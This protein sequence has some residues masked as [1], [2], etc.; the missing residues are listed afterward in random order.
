MFVC[1]RKILISCG[2][3]GVSLCEAELLFELF[4]RK[5]APL[6]SVSIDNT[7]LQESFISGHILKESKIKEKIFIKVR[8]LDT[9]FLTKP[10]SFS[11]HKASQIGPATCMPASLAPLA[12]FW[13]AN[14]ITSSHFPSAANCFASAISSFIYWI[15]SVSFFFALLAGASIDA[16]G[17]LF[18]KRRR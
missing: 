12:F 6:R 13:P 4:Y 11:T 9:G 3:R 5:T 18:A 17:M 16:A 10:V 2:F 7:D 14:T 1:Y 8:I 15:S